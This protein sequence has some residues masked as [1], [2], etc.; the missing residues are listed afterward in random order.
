MQRPV[1]SLIPPKS[2]DNT[3]TSAPPRPPTPTHECPSKAHKSY[4]LL[5]DIFQAPNAEDTP[6]TQCLHS[7]PLLKAK[8]VLEEPSSI[9]LDASKDFSLKTPFLPN[10]GR[11]ARKAAALYRQSGL[12][13]REVGVECGAGTAAATAAA[14]GRGHRPGTA[15]G[16]TGAIQ[17]TFRRRRPLSGRSRVPAQAAGGTCNLG[18]RGP[19]PSDTPPPRPGLPG[20]RALTCTASRSTRGLLG[21]GC[22][23]R[24]ALGVP[25]GARQ[26]ESGGRRQRRRPGRRRRRRTPALRSR[27]THPPPGRSA[28][29]AADHFRGAGQRGGAP[30]RTSWPWGRVLHGDCEQ[31]LYGRGGGA[32]VQPPGGPTASPRVREA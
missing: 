9:Q 7:L 10:T 26:E 16:A 22:A 30:G 12:K 31:R 15:L 6:I 29:A 32:V 27:E 17:V 2:P 23:D 5:L 21:L 4:L 18:G 20:R 11:E 19:G 13:A 28:A 1:N 24:T 25:R 14:P 8:P 3:T